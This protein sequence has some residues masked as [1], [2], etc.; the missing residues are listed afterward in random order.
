MPLTNKQKNYIIKNHKKQSVKSIAETLQI[1]PVEVEDFINSIS[2][3]KPKP[4]FYA[5]LILIPVLFFVLLEAGLRI[6]G[7]GTDTRMWTE[8]Q[9][10]KL[11]LNP[12]VAR[13]YFYN[14]KEVPQSIQDIF[15]ADKKENTFRVFVLGGSSAAG[16]P[17]MPLGSFSRYVR[18]R[19]ELVYPK[20]HIEVINIALT[21]VNS[22]TLLDFIPE[23]LEQKPDLILIYAGHNEYYGALGVGSMES[24]G[25]SRPL[26]NLLIKLNK[27]KTV[28]LLRNIIQSA[29]KMFAG[30][31]NKTTGTLMSRM[32]QKQSIF[33]NSD[34]YR[35]GLEQF[36]GNMTDILTKIKE[37]NIPVIIST[38]ASNLLDQR[39][40]ISKRS[41]TLPAA[42]EI[43]RDAQKFYQNGKLKSADSLFRYAKD[44]DLLRFRAPEAMNKII[45]S[46]SHSFNVP[47][48]NVD[49]VF[50]VASPGGIVGNNLMTD[51]LHP[52]LRGYQLMGKAFYETMAKKHF[53]PGDEPAINSLEK[54]DSATIK[55]FVFS[56]LD[57][58]IAD[59]KIKL[60]KNDWPFV[61]SGNK[62]PLSLLIHP[63]NYRDSLAIKFINKEI[64]WQTAQQKMAEWYLKNKNFPEF[65]KQ[66]LVLTTQYPHMLESYNRKAHK[67]LLQ[68][69]YKEAFVYLNSRYMIKPDAFSA[70]WIGIINLSK[71]KVPEAIKYLE[72]SLKFNP[73]DSQVLYNLAGAYS[74]K[75]NYKK[76]LELIN[77]SLEIDPDYK[78]AANLKSQLQLALKK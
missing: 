34:T 2:S 15:D 16:Y 30:N 58:V 5:V 60:L 50:N 21:A 75:K 62:K 65:H 57:S 56:G 76:A 27:F 53:L 54:Q 59:Y 37:R 45:K 32:A 70:K 36:E 18:K 29:M 33:L 55:N 26:V 22:Y 49:S 8:L 20:K 28:Q 10:G 47:L 68:K 6:A 77:K 17:F 1:N 72:E 40:F 11:G 4:L 67:L 74:L 44:L 42:N 64:D 23:V 46:L 38:L 73:D 48:V 52:T 69:K 66:M 7:Y 3:S 13:R 35:A 39:P 24:L 19:L 12:E 51:H 61:T 43:Y 25:T 31:D 78:E 9:N 14:V 63:E 71:N 41:E